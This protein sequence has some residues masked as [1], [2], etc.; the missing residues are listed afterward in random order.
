M[1]LEPTWHLTSAGCGRTHKRI[2]LKRYVNMTNIDQAAEFLFANR[3][4]Q[5]IVETIPD[6]IYPNSHT[7]AYLVQE[8]LIT[9]LTKNFDTTTCGYKLACTNPPVMKLLGVDEPFLGRMLNHSTHANGIV[10]PANSFV[11]RIVE[12]EFVFVM[13]QDVPN[14]VTP[15]TADTIKPFIEKFLPGIEIVDHRYTDFTQVGGN[16]LI[17]DNAIHGASIIGESD[18]NWQS[19]D[20]STHEIELSVNGSTW[21][22]GSGGNVLGSPLNVMAWL[23]N[24]LQSRG[25]GLKAGE[26]ITTGTA[27]DIYNAQPG[28]RV[29]A[30]FGELGSVSMSFT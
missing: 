22:K 7:G 6:N 10:L 19:I 13:D 4:D 15:Y 28:D 26:F 17:A 3:K 5:R 24:H 29:T 9:L 11:K 20:F 8:K 23:A 25:T 2:F 14:S 27:C 18:G 30:D 12:L 16:A 1:N 21:S